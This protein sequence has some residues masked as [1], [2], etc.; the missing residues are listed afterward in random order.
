M[1]AHWRSCFFLVNGSWHM[2]CSQQSSKGGVRTTR[3]GQ[4]SHRW[5]PW[6]PSCPAQ[7]LPA[8]LG[9]RLSLPH[10][11]SNHMCEIEIQVQGM[12]QVDHMP[13]KAC[14]LLTTVVVGA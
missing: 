12:V 11:E 10:L 4:Q 7:P 13:G 8:A 6:P 1:I 3:A 9:P 5:C 2:R 14:S